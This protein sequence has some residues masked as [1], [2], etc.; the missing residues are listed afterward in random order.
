MGSKSHI[1][2]WLLVF[3][4]CFLALSCT[5]ASYNN[6]KKISSKSGNTKKDGTGESSDNVISNENTKDI[7][8]GGR[9]GSTDKNG[10]SKLGLS[11]TPDNDNLG[12]SNTVR[13]ISQAIIIN[14]LEDIFSINLPLQEDLFSS[15]EGDIADLGQANLAIEQ[16]KLEDIF[17][18]SQDVGKH[19][20]DNLSDF[21]SCTN[22]SQASEQTNCITDFVK[23]KGRLL[24]RR[25]LN[26]EEVQLYL[27]EI[28]GNAASSFTE[29]LSLATSQLIT[30]P[31]FLYVVEIGGDPDSNGLRKLSD[32]ELITRISHMTTGKN[33]SDELLTIAENE[34][35]S[36][37]KDD[38]RNK[39]IE[40]LVKDI[41]TKN[42]DGLLTFFMRW[43]SVARI[44]QMPLEKDE[45]MFEFWS[46]ESPKHLSIQARE[47]FE[48]LL[49]EGKDFKSLYKTNKVPIN[50]Y[51]QSFYSLDQAYNQENFT[52]VDVNDKYYQGVITLPAII[53]LNNKS[54]V[55]SEVHNGLWV[56]ERVFCEILPNPPVAIFDSEIDRTKPPCSSCHKFIDDL[57]LALHHFNAAGQFSSDKLPAEFKATF[58][59]FPSGEDSINF[60]D[61]KGLGDLIVNSDTAKTCLSQQFFRYSLNRMEDSGDYCSINT[62]VSNLEKKGYQL[63]D[64]P[65]EI[66]K[67]R[68]FQYIRY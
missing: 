39:Y 64:L 65:V 32:L 57:G 63:Q 30:D 43:S 49:D 62:M 14:S 7:E 55:Q 40:E 21:S 51:T 66:S 17:N 35:I 36:K 15:L 33:P 16:I 12:V 38:E 31:N 56:R 2:K 47:F 23:N 4:V 18:I 9:D 44:S 22:S 19:V 11:C 50:Q 54:S 41:V 10:E 26:D 3:A 48:M 58:L 67:I 60:G 20:V 13:H 46:D 28:N 6:L 25:S 45:S 61:L 34:T 52:I 24:F 1:D 42:P 29:K 27:N 37:L 68:A 5:S 8:D 53:A 59:D